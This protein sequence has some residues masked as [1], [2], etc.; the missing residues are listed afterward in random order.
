MSAETMLAGPAAARSPAPAV[1]GEGLTVAYRRRV[2]LDVPSISLPA[3]GT[4]ALLGPSGAGKST[5]LRVLGLLERPT[6]GRVL[7]DDVEVRAGDLGARRRIAAVFQKPYLL[8]GTI[9]DNVG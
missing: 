6:S 7:L 1:R 8:R 5:L 9:A 3:G 4:Y 2:V